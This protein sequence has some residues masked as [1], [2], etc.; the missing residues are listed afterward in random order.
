M[1]FKS[2]CDIHPRNLLGVKGKKPKLKDTQ[3]H[4]I[5]KHR[6]PSPHTEHRSGAHVEFQDHENVTLC[7]TVALGAVLRRPD[8]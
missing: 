1:A 7:V 2:L 5:L 6:L 3:F 8:C 4:R